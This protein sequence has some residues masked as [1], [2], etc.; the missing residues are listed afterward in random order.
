MTTATIPTILTSTILTVI[1]TFP[2]TPA[3]RSPLTAHPVMVTGM[4]VS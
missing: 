2:S 1:I 3:H 4:L